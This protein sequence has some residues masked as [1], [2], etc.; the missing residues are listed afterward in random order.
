VEQH[1]VGAVVARPQEDPLD[2]FCSQP[3]VR[4]AALE[5]NTALQNRE[6]GECW[7]GRRRRPAGTSGGPLLAQADP[8]WRSCCEHDHCFGVA[9]RRKKYYQ[10]TAI[11]DCTRLRVLR[12]HPRCDQKTAIAF[13]ERRHGQT[14]FR[15]SARANRHPSSAPPSTG[16]CSTKASTRFTSNPARHGSTAKVERSHRIEAR[17]KIRWPCGAPRCEYGHLRQH[18]PHDLAAELAGAND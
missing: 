11:D 9:V 8:A 3:R 12:A 14:P 7:S 16:T 10:F 2:L 17:A 4:F 1:S 5:L 15:S 18:N 6:T 13:I